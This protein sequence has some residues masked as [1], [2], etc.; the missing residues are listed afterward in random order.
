M[1]L[2]VGIACVSVVATALGGQRIN[3]E[4]RILGPAPAIAQSVLFDTPADSINQYLTAYV[5]PLLH[6][7]E[8]SPC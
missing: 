1:K 4:G 6:I 2:L 8:H 5:C 7:F 3:Q